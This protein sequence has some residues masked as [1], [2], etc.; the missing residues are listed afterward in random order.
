MRNNRI[1]LICARL[2]AWCRIATVHVDRHIAIWGGWIA[3]PAFGVAMMVAP[4]YF[5]LTPPLSAFLFWS[6]IIVFILTLVVVFVLS[7]QDQE[8]KRRVIGPILLM[9]AGALVFGGGAAWYLWPESD[10]QQSTPPQALQAT[11]RAEEKAPGAETL[12]IGS[13]VYKVFS[14]VVHM[15]VRAKTASVTLI[16]ELT[17]DAHE[18]GPIC[19]QENGPIECA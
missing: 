12:P 15:D 1:G 2:G 10:S 19:A 13:F 7:L 18:N 16:V 5:K 3:G 14:P 9:T 6:G 8:G 4:D 11:P 17:L